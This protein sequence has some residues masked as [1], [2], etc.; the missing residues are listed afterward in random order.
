MQCSDKQLAYV[1]PSQCS[2]MQLAK[3]LAVA[4]C[5]AAKCSDMQL[6]VA[7]QPKRNALNPK[8]KTLNSLDTQRAAENAYSSHRVFGTA[9]AMV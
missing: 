4:I 9:H 5:N 8:P 1:V 2:D 6:A 7:Y 3:T